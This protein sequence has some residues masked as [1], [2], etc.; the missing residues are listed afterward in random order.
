MSDTEIRLKVELTPECKRRLNLT[1]ADEYLKFWFYIDTNRFGTVEQ[2]QHELFK[3]ITT[4]LV[5]NKENNNNKSNK[6][7]FKYHKHIDS[8]QIRLYIQNCEL[9]LFEST[10]LLRDMDTVV[11]V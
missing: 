4:N 6:K 1:D 9:P 8:L 2:F 5:K 10:N 7:S 3:R 11:L